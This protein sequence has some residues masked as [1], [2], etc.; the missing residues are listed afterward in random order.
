MACTQQ[1]SGSLR[2]FGIPLQRDEA[3]PT[4]NTCQYLIQMLRAITITSQFGS[5]AETV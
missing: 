1:Q 2:R 5:A 3:T 4:S